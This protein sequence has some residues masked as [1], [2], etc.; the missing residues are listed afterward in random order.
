MES[1][2]TKSPMTAGK[3]DPNYWC[4]DEKKG[5]IYSQRKCLTRQ[6]KVVWCML[7][8]KLGQKGSLYYFLSLLRYI[9]TT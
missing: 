5:L 1:Q 2:F 3:L 6:L 7:A 8:A 9:T 4:V